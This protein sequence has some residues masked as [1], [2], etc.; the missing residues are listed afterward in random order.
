MK[1][2]VAVEKTKKFYTKPLEE[3]IETIKE[4][5]L[6]HL[7][8]IIQNYIDNINLLD[9]KEI[10]R[11]RLKQQ[12]EFKLKPDSTWKTYNAEQYVNT[13]SM[14][15]LW[16]AKIRMAPFMNIHV[17]DE[18]IDGKG[19]LNAKLFNFITVVDEKGPKLDK[20]EFLRFLSEM[21]WYPTFYLN[22][23]IIWNSKG[24]N[25]VE[26]ELSENNIT[27]TG[28]ILFNTDGLIKEFSAERYYTNGDDKSLEEWHGYWD[29]YKIIN[30]VLIPTKFKVCWH[31]DDKKYCY[32]RGEVTDIEFN[33]PNIY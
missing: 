17:I 2:K 20:G 3:R 26:V 12:G 4:D 32:I 13:E 10:K 29:S 22:K 30:N 7:P 16:Y 1:S 8:D 21:P 33:N 15:F 9:N 27:I 23:K 11:V 28:T 31:L 14:S 24:E 6:A 18:Y 25:V 5:D 19:K